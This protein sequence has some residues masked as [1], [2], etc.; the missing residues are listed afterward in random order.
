MSRM[1]W[2]VAAVCLFV[3]FPALAQA[4]ARGDSLLRSGTFAGLALREIG[5]ATTSGRIADIA[6]DPTRPST[7]Y[8]AVAS[9]GVWKTV[10]AGTTWTPIFDKQGSY[11]IGV[12]TIDPRNPLTIWV[13]TGENNSQR[14][15]G[16][17]DGV[18]KSVDGGV[19]WK[20]MGLRRSEHIGAIEVDPRN[21]DVV[22]VAAQGPLWSAGGERGLYKTTDGGATWKLVLAVDE[23]TGINEVHL[24]P[25]NPDV[26]YAS[27][28]QRARRVWTLIDGGP[29]SAIYKST[30]AGTTWTRLV[31]GLPSEEMGLIGLAVSPANPDVVYAIIEA[32]DR[33]SGVYR[34]TNAGGTRKKMSD[35]VSS[36]PQYYQ[37]LVAD[38]KA[39]DRVYSMDTFMMRTED[40]GRTFTRV[41]ERWK[42]VDNHALWIDPAD[43]D[44]LLAGCDGGIYES[45]DRGATWQFKPNL[46][47]TQFYKVAVDNALPFY[48][49]YGGTQDNASLGGPSRTRTDHGIQNS[50]WFVTVFGDGF[51]TQVDPEDPNVVYSQS[52]YAGLVRFDRKTGETIDIQPQPG[53]GEPPIRWN[54]D[55]PLIIS[56]HSHT[57]LY[58]AGNRLFRSDDRGDSWTPV[59]PDLTRQLDRNALKVMG[60]VWS[61][62][63]VAKNT[64]TSFYGNITA[65]TESP[66]KVGL[67]YVGTDDGLIQVTEDGGG[68]W[69]TIDKVPGVPELT[70][71]ARV[72]ASRHREG[73]VYAA[74]N[75]HKM[76]DFAP[77][78]FR[79][80]DYGRTWMSIT[81]NL[82]ARG[83]VWVIQEDHVNPDLLFAGTEFGLFFTTDGGQRWV[84]LKGGGFPVI[85]VRDLAIQRRENDL[86]VGTFGRGIWILDDYTPLRAMSP[87]G[88]E[89]A[90]ILF[91]VKPASIFVPAR[92]LGLGGKSMQ[93]DAYYTAPNPPN[94]AV[95]TYYL[96]DALKTRRQRRQE[97]EKEASKKGADVPY[98]SWDSLRVED[99][100]EEPAVILT[101]RDEGG[102]V[103]RRLRGPASAGISRVTWDLRYPAFAPVSLEKSS[104]DNPF[105]EPPV[106]PLVPPGTY[107]VSME[108]LVDGVPT[109]VPGAQQ[110]EARPLGAGSLPEPD[111]AQVIAFQQATGQLQRAVLGTVE[112]L[113]EADTRL[114]HLRK[115]LSETPVAN[116]RLDQQARALAAR[117][118]DLRTRLTGDATIARRSEPTPPSLVDRVQ[119]IVD[120]HW[121]TTQSATA[122]HRRNYDIAAAEF[123]P[124]LEQVRRLVEIDLEA[125]EDEAERAG[126]PWTPGRVP[127]WRP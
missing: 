65:L 32:Q 81:G 24:D 110:F 43:T 67:I 122:T 75:N 82:P 11:S 13:G 104:D 59:S 100:E 98:P 103:V 107:Q 87:A 72:E 5:P 35:Y 111:R 14:S 84:Q 116:L 121:F 88:L 46:P 118:A 12:V 112:V 79:S 2:S 76:G 102:R 56:P 123:G 85:A 60:R 64:S 127:A 119:R 36:S 63:A 10:N 44:H 15:V 89:Q 115:A 26:L 37:E 74:F 70:Y 55:S 20:H 45:W 94:G 40:G 27:A 29:G 41:G 52:Q 51:Q 101:V 25:R 106:G 90:A 6:V 50:D 61:V 96:R 57:R 17:G 16:D 77:Y 91:A 117:L 8:V 9:G 7:W 93:G 33:A 95:F 114:R 83:S 21:S 22:Y 42:H 30:D 53:Q 69:R 124:L 1:S 105:R 19:T 66:L 4:P 99:R 58:F 97:A 31:N 47:V 120:G 86:V 78:L 38:P 28:Y 23:H 39:P 68:S 73:R 49:V 126:A 125:L 108:L 48:N 34:S 3:A 92:P 62:D 80:D 71:V 113:R 54:W 109:A 18:Y